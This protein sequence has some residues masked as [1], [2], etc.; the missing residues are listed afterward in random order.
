LYFLGKEN[1]LDEL[2]TKLRQRQQYIKV[3]SLERKAYECVELLFRGAS[4]E[5]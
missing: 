1:E 4:G 5:M 3:E 2:A